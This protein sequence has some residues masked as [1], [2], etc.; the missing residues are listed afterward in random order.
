MAP[1]DHHVKS[2]V[3]AFRIIRALERWGEMGVTE[4]TNETG[5][6]KSSVHK[7]LVTLRH[8]GYV[9]KSGSLY[10]LSLRWFQTGRKIRERHPVYRIA[11]PELDRLARM[12]GETVSLVVQEEGA[13]VY[14]YQ[15]SEHD[16]PVGPVGEGE[17]IPLPISVGGKAIL[18]YRPVSEVETLLAEND[19][20]EE[21]DQLLSE[22][23]T[24]RSQRMVIERDSPQQGTF[25][26]GAF[27]GHRHVVGHDKPYRD[28]HSVAVPVRAPDDYAVGAIEVSGS[29]ASL[30]GRRLEEEIASLL[31]NTG[32][33]IE[34][35]L[36][37]QEA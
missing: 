19:L 2:D 24:L 14:L 32:K 17:R 13:A 8:L 34:T 29:E 4:I 37:Q 6:G 12:T 18:S 31:V 28:L 21:T 3:T 15:A 9:T 20:T 16:D 23:R 30:Y 1:P 10:S 5:I 25:S 33:T 22:L 27:E 26:A 11:R 7:H 35:D 36:I